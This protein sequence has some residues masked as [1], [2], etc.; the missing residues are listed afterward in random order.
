MQI[1]FSLRRSRFA[2]RILLLFL[3]CAF[4]P[5]LLLVGF[6][7]QRV[8]SQLH[9]Q[10]WVRMEK[11]CKTYALGVL[12]RLV[13]M[14][15]LVRLSAPALVQ[16]QP[17]AHLPAFQH[18][19]ITEKFFGLGFYH[20][21]SG[22]QVLHGHLDQ[23]L[24]ISASFDQYLQ[25]TDKTTLFIGP[26]D[27]LPKPL[28]LLIPVDEGPR[29]GLLVARP[30]ESLLWGTGMHSLL[31]A[32]TEMAVYDEHGRLIAATLTSPGEQ[33]P[34]HANRS[35]QHYLQFQYTQD[36]ETYLASGWSL[37]LASHFNAPTWTVILS[38]SVSDVLSAMVDF[39]YTFPLIILLVLWIV[40]FLALYF[41]RKTLTPLALLREGTKRISA[42][43]FSQPL[44]IASGDEFEQ[45]AN[46]FNSMSS[47]LHQQFH[48]LALIDQIDRAILSSLD[49]SIIIPRSLRLIADFFSCPRIVLAQCSAAEP[50]RL[51]LTLLTGPSRNDLTSDHALLNED[52]WPQLFADVPYT[53]LRR[54]SFLPSFLLQ[55]P[56]EDDLFLV[57]PLKME[58]RIQGAL[59]LSFPTT[60]E[61]NAEGTIAQARQLADQLSIALENA[62]LVA[63]LEQLSIG[64]VEALARTV[65]AKSKWTAG[66]SERVAE[67]AVRIGRA[68][69]CGKGLLDHLHRGGLLHDIGK[70]G[71]PIAILDK[72]G[73]LDEQ[74]YATIKTHPELGGKIIEPIQP[75]QEVVPIIVQ[76]HERFDGKGYPQGLAGE[77]INLGARILCLAD[78][79][80]ALISQRPYRDGWV[81]EQAL[82]FIREN[83]GSMF[84]PQVVD[85][86]FS[87][88]G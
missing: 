63:D 75:Y 38:A 15:N 78:V 76:H 44:R 18:K 31:P 73:K 34:A 86:F 9:E 58:R 27:I 77:A 72:P 29:R 6:A 54:E 8:K 35:Q 55:T 61:L 82:D 87:L 13:H 28:Y 69:Q 67:L 1:P 48:T 46:S 65:D 21:D 26:S 51:R 40:L 60:V 12:D 33:L 52:E 10:S 66:H 17:V 47:Q 59:I 83:S 20:P 71:I 62:R 36:Q 64:A 41:I 2:R 30:E 43:D 37:F 84:D 25:A 74:E 5:T 88:E 80:D 85:A 81:K 57:L 68:M 7:Y 3:L 32:M 16:G 14:D 19:Q 45:L 4:L 11:E 42:R 39:Q 56:S 49:T 79:Y 70:I 50:N 22:L 23:A 53:I 24:Q